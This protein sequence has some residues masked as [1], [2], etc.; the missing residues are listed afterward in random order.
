MSVE[1]YN[2][3]AQQFFSSTVE[4]DSTSLLDQ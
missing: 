2:Q 4:V 1:F 3:N